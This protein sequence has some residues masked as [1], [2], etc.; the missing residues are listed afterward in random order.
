LELGVETQE[1]YLKDGQ[2]IEINDEF[3]PDLAN[4]KPLNDET[5]VQKPM[6]F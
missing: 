1:P 5:V 6:T 4:V 3:Q 2:S